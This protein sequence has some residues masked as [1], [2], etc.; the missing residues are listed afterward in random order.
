MIHILLLYLALTLIKIPISIKQLSTTW[1]STNGICVNKIV[2]F[3]QTI[4]YEVEMNVFETYWL[5][6]CTRYNHI[7]LLSK[8]N[9]SLQEYC[10]PINNIKEIYKRTCVY[11]YK[12]FIS[13]LRPSQPAWKFGHSWF[14]LMFP[15]ERLRVKREKQNTFY[16]I[17]K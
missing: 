7:Y 12:R 11:E 15:V 3:Y 14:H 2:A 6:F 13:L 9:A 1:K 5:Y 8:H 10:A 17:R 4:D 16:T